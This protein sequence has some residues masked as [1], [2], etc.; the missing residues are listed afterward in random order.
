MSVTLHNSPKRLARL[1]WAVNAAIYA[2]G[3]SLPVSIDPRDVDDARDHY[4]L[5]AYER[6]GHA[7]VNLNVN[8]FQKVARLIAEANRATYIAR[9]ATEVPPLPGNFGYESDLRDRRETAWSVLNRFRLN[10]YPY[11]L[12]G[13][14]ALA[15]IRALQYELA[16]AVMGVDDPFGERG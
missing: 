14:L 9:Y 15:V 11:T 2:A 4:A 8:E 3:G 1:A 7:W 5:N 12:H 16:E 13:R 10:I 6:G